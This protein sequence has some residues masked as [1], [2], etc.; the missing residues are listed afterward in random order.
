MNEKTVL[1]ATDFGAV[2]DGEHD[3]TDAFS[4]CIEAVIAAGGGRMYIPSG[5]YLGNIVIPAYQAPSWIV[6]EIVGDRQPAPVGAQRCTRS[7]TVTGRHGFS[8][9]QLDVEIAGSGQ[10]DAHNEWQRTEVNVHDPESLGTGD[11]NYWV[12]EG[13]V[14]AVDAFTMTG[15]ESIRA[16]RV[17]HS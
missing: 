14:G 17:G 11:I 15:G 12:V 13:N 9:Q 16:R 8:I 7:I 4:A 5:L 2:G 3:N 1:D 10:S 6:I